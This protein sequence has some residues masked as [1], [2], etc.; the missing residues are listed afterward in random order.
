MNDIKHVTIA[1]HYILVQGMLIDL[2]KVWRGYLS[3]RIIQL[4][5][6]GGHSLEFERDDGAGVDVAAGLL[7]PPT[8]DKLKAYLMEKLQPEPVA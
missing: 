4:Q 2:G 6:I 7:D 1:P 3:D 5:F 8:F